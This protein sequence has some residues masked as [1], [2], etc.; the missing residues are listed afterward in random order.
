MSGNGRRAAG[1]C[2]PTNVLPA[3]ASPL[4]EK[5]KDYVLD[6]IGTGKWGREDR[7]PSENDLVT[8]LGVSRMTVHR[9]LRELTSQGHLLRIQGVGIFVAPPRPQSALI[10]INNIASEITQRG[11]R[12]AARVILL[13]KIAPSAPS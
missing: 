13:E 7:L 8:A 10:E 3:S 2:S 6:N 9:A 5:V 11:G 4:Y 12:H 1:Q